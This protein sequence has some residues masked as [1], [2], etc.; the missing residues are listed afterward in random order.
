[1]YQYKRHANVFYKGHLRTYQN[2][3]EN[4]GQPRGYV[5][6]GQQKVHYVS[7][8]NGLVYTYGMILSHIIHVQNSFT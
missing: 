4:W 3:V 1:M 5:Y 2:N 7:L 6:K 8:K